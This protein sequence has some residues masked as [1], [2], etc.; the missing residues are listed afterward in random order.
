MPTTAGDFC[1]CTTA[2][3]FVTMNSS[4]PLRPPLLISHMAVMLD[5]GDS[6][7]SFGDD[8]HDGLSQTPSLRRSDGVIGTDRYGFNIR[9]TA[10]EDQFDANR[11]GVV[12][13]PAELT[14]RREKE[15]ERLTKWV[16]MMKD[17]NN[18]VSKKK[19]KLK[20]RVRKGIPDAVR[21]KVWMCFVEEEAKK[22]KRSHPI[23]LLI[24]KLSKDEVSEKTLEDIEKDV[25]RTFPN[26]V[27]FESKDSSGQRSLRTILSWYAAVD[28]DVGY[29]QG[30]GFIAAMF[31][32]YLTEEE[33]FYTLCAGKFL[34]NYI[35]NFHVLS[36]LLL[37]C[38]C[39][40]HWN[41][42]SATF[43]KVAFEDIRN[44]NESMSTYD[45]L[46][47]QFS[48]SDLNYYLSLS[49]TDEEFKINDASSPDT[50]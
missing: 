30:M 27:Q 34:L 4:P 50:R 26:H 7:D 38:I 10:E 21:G 40:L 24:E 5:E 48:L 47:R 49:L 41:L 36:N 33:A 44:E 42:L 46:W 8:D 32:T 39:K 22:W 43:P 20:R 13:S 3:L 9:A 25:D 11:R 2:Q 35:C 15:A 14:A 1:F 37:I 17:W 19:E 31:L 23:S 18:T 12:L 45:L 28:P 29:C 6:L 16:K